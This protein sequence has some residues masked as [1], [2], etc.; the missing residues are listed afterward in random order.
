MGVT[1]TDKPGTAHKPDT[2]AALLGRGRPLVMG[3]L[4]VTPDSFSDGGQFIDADKAIVHARAM[5]Q[6]GADILDIGAESTRPYGGAKPVSAENELARLKSVLPAVVAFGLPVSIDTIKAKIAAWAL[7]QGGVIVN[8]V[9][10]LQRDPDMA[11][12]IAER[13]CPVIVMHNRESVDARLD[14][15]ADIADFFSRSLEIAARAGVARAQI[16]LDPG[17]GFG[18]TPEQSITCLARFA[19]L[20][21]FGLPLLVGASRKRFINAVA[22]S[23]PNERLGGSISAHL[24]AAANGAAILRVH[25]VAE[26]VQAL[27]VAAAIEAA[28]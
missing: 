9:W 19:E 17:I 10:G 11:P 16:V 2:L 25:D 5:A 27:R 6:Q 14:I 28:R 8:D 3:I 13:G 12:L 26:T 20:K 23:A 24:M 21:R 18:K 1:V 15:M 7:D 4:N 22:P